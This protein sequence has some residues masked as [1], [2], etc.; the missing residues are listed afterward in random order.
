MLVGLGRL[1][2]D[3]EAVALL[4][5]G[6]SPY[7]LLR[8][9]GAA[10]G[11][12]RARPP[13]YVMMVAIPERQPDLPRDHLRGRLQA[14]RDATSSPRVFFQ[15]FPGWVLYAREEPDPGSPAGRSSWSPGPTRRPSTTRSTS[16]NAAGWSSTAPKRTVDLVL[17]DGTSYSISQDRAG[18]HHPLPRRAG[19]GPQP[20]RGVP[21]DQHPARPQREDHRRA[22]A[23]MADKIK[24]GHVAA[25]RKSSRSSRSSRSRWP[26]WCSR[27]SAWRSDDGGPRRQARRLRRRHRR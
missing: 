23:D 8:P 11:G 6:V 24:N 27:W 2:A 12:R 18:R 26:A 1:S 13:L 22:A 10:G 21:E 9:I 3:R 7:R 20:G 25:S 14:G 17:E 19:P 4:A 15:D 16:P 5:C